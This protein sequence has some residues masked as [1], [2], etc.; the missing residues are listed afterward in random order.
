MVQV[1]L[2]E[3]PEAFQVHC[4]GRRAAWRLERWQQKLSIGAAAYASDPLGLPTCPSA[5]LL[6]SKLH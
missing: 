2:L 5:K 3:V 4:R 1:R 6:L